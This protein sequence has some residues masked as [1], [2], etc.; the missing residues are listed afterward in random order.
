MPTQIFNQIC[1]CVCSMPLERYI[2]EC[3]F[4]LKWNGMKRRPMCILIKLAATTV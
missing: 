3:V 4:C 2:Y 1:V